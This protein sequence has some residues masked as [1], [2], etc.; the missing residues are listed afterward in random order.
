MTAGPGNA[1]DETHLRIIA[2][3]QPV[4]EQLGFGLAGGNALRVHGLSNRPTRDINMFTPTEGAI[5]KAVPLVE[6]AL[7]AAGFDA[8]ATGSQMTGLVRDWGDY[9]ARW[10]VT[11]GE[12]RV[13]L[14]LSLH[15]LLSPPVS[16]QDIG[17]VLSAEDVLASKILAMVDRAAARDFVDVYEAMLQG[18][19]PE[20]LIALAWRLNPDDYDAEYFTQVLPNLADL[21]DFEFEQFGLDP[22]RVKELRALFDRQWPTRQ[23]G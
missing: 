22:A 11:A 15:E 19:T 14:E 5:A 10:I 6:Q 12:R 16:I 17:L 8:R 23:D 21:D 9:T 3:I 4:L 2:V 1:I 7:R 18:W 20:Q 13:L